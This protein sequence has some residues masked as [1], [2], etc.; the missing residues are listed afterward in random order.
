MNIEKS[1]KTKLI[2]KFREGAAEFGLPYR[3]SNYGPKNTQGKY[4]SL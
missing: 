4:D 1:P 2:D 3:D